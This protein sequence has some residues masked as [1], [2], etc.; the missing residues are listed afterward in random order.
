[1]GNHGISSWAPGASL[2]DPVNTFEPERLLCGL[3]LDRR[4][5]ITADRMWL[6]KGPTSV[7]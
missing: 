7:A 2:P 5:A 3:D 4:A 1:M 6:Q